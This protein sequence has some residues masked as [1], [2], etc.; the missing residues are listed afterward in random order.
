MNSSLICF[1]FRN[2][3]EIRKYFLN[4]PVIDLFVGYLIGLS[5]KLENKNYLNGQTTQ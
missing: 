2:K 3:F 4:K 1:Y 5:T